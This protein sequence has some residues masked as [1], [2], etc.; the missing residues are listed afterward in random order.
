M[1]KGSRVCPFDGQALQRKSV[2]D[3]ASENRT[4]PSEQATFRTSWVCPSARC[5]YAEPDNLQRLSLWGG[6]AVSYNRLAVRPEFRELDLEAQWALLVH[7]VG[8]V[9]SSQLD[10]VASLKQDAAAQAE[11]L[12]WLEKQRRESD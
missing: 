11:I 2:L 10:A 5:T 6:L 3:S 7:A 4:W 9:D 8:R 1:P 12:S